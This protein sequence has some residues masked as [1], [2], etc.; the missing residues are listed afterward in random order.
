MESGDKTAAVEEDEVDFGE[1]EFSV[2]YDFAKQELAV[3][4]LQCQNLPAMDMGGTSDPYVKVFLMPEKK[5]K[6][7][8]K[9]HRKTLSPVYNETFVFKEIEYADIGEKTICF[10]IFDFD[11]FS[12]HDQ[13]GQLDVPLN[14]IDLGK[15]VQEWR[16]VSPPQN[17]DNKEIHL[18]EICFSLRYVPNTGKLTVCVLEAKNLKQMDLGGFSGKLFD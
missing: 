9:V 2:D 10:Q 16:D 12:K 6:F 8:T 4:V 13:I 14:S 5:K 7:E 18:G 3:A 11:R 1:L 17:D 15:V